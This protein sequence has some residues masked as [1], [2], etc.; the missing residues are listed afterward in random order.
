M[1]W[2]ERGGELEQYMMDTLRA[3]AMLRAL[4]EDG[5]FSTR[6]VQHELRNAI[7]SLT[8][9]NAQVTVHMSAS[10]YVSVLGALARRLTD[11]GETAQ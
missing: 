3:R 8:D 5:A 1:L 6:H 10:E 7:A 9:Q 2:N 11:L 4:S